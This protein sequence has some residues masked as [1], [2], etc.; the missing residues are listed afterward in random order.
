MSWDIILEKP[1]PGTNVDLFDESSL[2]AFDLTAVQNFL[3]VICPHITETRP[4]WMLY[5]ERSFEM[6]FDLAED[7][8]MLHVHILEPTGEQ[9][10]LIL[11]G[12]ICKKLQCRAFDTGGDYLF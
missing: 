9:Q 4:L 2:E 10:F 11:L 6:E 8:I 12:E 1:L 7:F 5:E 3:R